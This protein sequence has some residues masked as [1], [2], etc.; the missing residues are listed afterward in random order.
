MAYQEDVNLNLNVLSGTTAGFTAIMGGMSAM[1]SSFAQMG[2]EAANTF[3]GIDALVVGTTALITAFAV[4]SAKAFGEYE[5]G[6]KIVQTV[7]GQTGS[8]MNE[9]SNKANDLSVAYRTSMSDI[10]EG[11]QTLGRAGLNSANEQL[12]VLESG[13]QTAK[14]EG[15]NLNG[16][17]EELIQNTAMLGGDLKSTNFGEQ[18]EYLNSLMV[19]T[20]MTAPI[21][22]HDI[23]QTLQYSGGTLAAAG[24]S[25]D[26]EEE[27]KKLI[28]D[29]M[30]TVAAF[31]QRGVKGSMAGTALRAFFTKP[32]SQDKQVTAG[33]EAIGLTPEDLWEDGG[34]KMR[35]VSDQ[36]SIIENQMK[37]LNLS[38]MDQVEI[39]GKIVGAK[40]GQQM[41]K[42]HSS[43]I[44]ELTRDIQDSQSTETL[45]AQTLQTYNQKL[46]EFQQ[47]GEVAYREFGEK[48]ARIL[49]PLIEGGT[50]LMELLSNPAVN[51]SVFIAIGSLVGHGLSTAWNMLKSIYGQLRQLFSDTTTG[52]TNIN[53][54]VSGLGTGF[55]Q[56]A[57]QVDYLNN[58]LSETDATLQAI[59]AR[60]LGLKPGYI[61]P[62]GLA[63][64]KIPRDTLRI[65]GENVIKDD[66]GVMGDR[67]GQ[68]YSGENEDLFK[69]KIKN[70][71]E[72]I[73]SNKEKW[74]EEF[75]QIKVQ[76]EEKLDELTARREER[77]REITAQYRERVSQLEKV[78]DSR[79]SSVNEKYDKL[80]SQAPDSYTKQSIE[81][82]RQDAINKINQEH[83]SIVGMQTKKMN[84]NLSNMRAKNDKEVQRIED[85]FAS[86]ESSFDQRILDSDIRLSELKQAEKQGMEKLQT[87]LELNSAAEAE[88]WY[89]NLVEKELAGT[90]TEEEAYSLKRTRDV[91]EDYQNQYALEQMKKEGVLPTYRSRIFEELSPNDTM[92]AQI[93]ESGDYKAIADA[94]KKANENA[95]AIFA[96]ENTLSARA[97]RNSEARLKSF[98]NRLQ[99]ANNR[100]RQFGTDLSNTGSRMKRNLGDRLHGTNYIR[101]NASMLQNKGT[102]LVTTELELAGKSMTTALNEV[103]ARLNISAAEFAALYDSEALAEMGLGRLSAQALNFERTLIEAM[104]PMDMEEEERAKLII[105]L[106]ESYRAHIREAGAAGASGF[107]GATGQATGALGKLGGAVGKVVDFMGGPLMAGMMAFTVG[108]QLIQE[109]QQSWQEAMQEAK[110]ELSEAADA[111]SEINQSIKDTYSAENPNMTEADLEKA[112]DMQYSSI[113]DAFYSGAADRSILGT[114]DIVSDVSL[115][116]SKD[117]DGNYV[118]LTEEEIAAR[119]DAAS[120]I[121][122]AKDENVQALKENTMELVA[123]TQAYSQAQSKEADEFNN[124]FWGF[125]GSFSDFTDFMGNAQEALWNTGAWLSAPTT[126][127][128]AR[129][130]FLDDDSPILTGSQSDSN[131]EGSKEFAGI[132]AADTYRFHNDYYQDDQRKYAEGLKQFF[133]SDYDRIIS[134]LSSMNGKISTGYGNASGIDAIYTHSNNMASMSS[135]Q[136]A[137]AQTSLANNKEDYQRLGKQMFRYEQSRG[138]SS[139]RTAY[140]DYNNIGKAITAQKKGDT[141]T[142]DKAMKNLGKSKI[143]TQDKNLDNT[144]KKLMSLTGNKLDEQNIL[145]MGQLQQLQDMQTIASEQISPGIMST[146][147]GVYNNI[148]STNIAGSNAGEAAGGAISA[149]NN[150][151]AI[152][153]ILGAKAQEEAEHAAFKEY[154]RAGGR[155]TDEDAFIAAVARGELPDYE[156]KIL[157]SLEGTSWSLVNGNSDPDAVNKNGE[158]LYNKLNQNS[159]Y[160]EKLNTATWGIVN[161]ASKRILDAYD[162]SSVGEYG[163]GS[164]GTGNGSGGGDSGS[165]DSDKNSG[166][167][168]ERV[169]LVLCNKKEIPKLNVNLFKKA[170]NFTVLNKNFR[171]RDIKINSEDKPKA[172]MN[173]VKNGI[174]ETQK[175][176]DPKIIQDETAEYNPVEATDGSSTPSGTTKTTT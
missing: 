46:S 110:N 37:R 106:E 134:L 4:E 162:Q 146:V 74:E 67:R 45:A 76:K 96:G 92:L 131:Y 107:G 68:Y 158:R 26:N 155:Y 51:T 140:G 171:L 24:G 56:S 86:Q 163:N 160:Q 145:A 104:I 99:S 58:K 97:G 7:S 16:V 36:I 8:A 133:G 109:W 83:E 79:I 120:Q 40:M 28:E 3:G 118:P 69:S 12:E 71:K 89:K 72:E 43:D 141:K 70:E 98:E 87:R 31:A 42:L 114:T 38:T 123:A 1:T 25:L 102:K 75:E 60:S 153:G 167:K 77:E 55:Q 84:T 124:G 121:T 19:G 169:D 65:M 29:Y 132:F 108:M 22:S 125:D 111:F 135:E 39:W 13:L 61:T 78:R 176:M 52:L 144:I 147:Q 139:G 21:D 116:G 151:A 127:G 33:L 173:A 152:A 82:Q 138:L 48:V 148:S 73:E 172:I 150:A 2:S 143:T 11:L 112:V 5:Q 35:S 168:K 95:A 6:M 93:Y 20:S 166:T 175:R 161:Y 53:G 103:A 41:M 59:Q 34:T 62:G 50:K 130:G 30:G 156:K 27:G 165:G 105:A 113:Y 157:T 137:L 47:Q 81:N 170:P 9:L 18:T 88:R 126:G 63:G 57:S 54:L 115:S 128:D 44:K 94:R 64:D 100:L 101:D 119:S 15:R 164:R 129:K 159:S 85:K 122:V 142:Y 23:S 32:A 136:M 14:L 149:A 80:Y 117:Q 91:W 17:L 154:Q 10:T 49:T 174:I 66:F 90:I